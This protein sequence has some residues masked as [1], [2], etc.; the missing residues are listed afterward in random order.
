MP[1]GEKVESKGV[2]KAAKSLSG[3]NRPDERRNQQS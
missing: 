2:F 3:Q 1:G